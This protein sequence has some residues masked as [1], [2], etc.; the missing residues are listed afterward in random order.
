MEI[1]R[2]DMGLLLPALAAAKAA[3][4]PQSKTVLPSKCFKYEEMPVKPNGANRQRA[5]LN[6]ATHGGFGV[7]AHLTELGPGMAPHAPHHHAHEELVLLQSGTLDVTISGKTTRL[8]PG[9]VAFVASNEEH[10][11]KNASTTERA[12]YFIVTLGRDAT[13][14]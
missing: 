14:A 3:A 9:S 8:T 10:G 6:G 12:Q 11:W 7:E 5:V 1:K 2:R 13:A 4:Q